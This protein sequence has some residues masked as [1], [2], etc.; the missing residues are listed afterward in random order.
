M[1]IRTNL[2]RKIREILQSGEIIKEKLLWR[3]KDYRNFEQKW[4]TC[5]LQV[6]YY[7]EDSR[8][9]IIYVMRVSLAVDLSLSLTNVP[10]HFAYAC[11]QSISLLFA[12]LLKCIGVL[13]DYKIILQ[14]F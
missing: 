3:N 4:E 13:L 14:N 2:S 1:K 12:T 9:V 5:Y 7:F 8:S 11:L 10:I 6:C